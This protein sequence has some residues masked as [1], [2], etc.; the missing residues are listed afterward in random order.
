MA[1]V[2]FTA[3]TG[4]PS[5]LPQGYS[6]HSFW[7]CIS[8]PPGV[9]NNARGEC[10]PSVADATGQLCPAA[11]AAVPAT[12]NSLVQAL[13]KGLRPNDTCDVQ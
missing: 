11:L 2:S 6:G 8:L 5:H 1:A 3:T 4:V 12:N 7:Q 13:H 10:G 9:W